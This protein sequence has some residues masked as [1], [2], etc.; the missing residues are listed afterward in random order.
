M[1]RDDDAAAAVAGSARPRRRTRAPSRAASAVDRAAPRSRAPARASASARA[2]VDARSDRGACDLVGGRA[3]HRRSIT[4]GAPRRASPVRVHDAAVHARRCRAPPN[5]DA[6]RT[7]LPL[8]PRPARAR[9]S[10]SSSSAGSCACRRSS[11]TSL[12]GIV[13]G[14]HALALG[15]GIDETTRYLA[16]FGIVFLMFSIGLEF[17]LPQLRAMRRAVFGLGL[18]Q[19]AITTVAGDGRRCTVVGFG[20]QAGLVLGGA[21]AMSST[22]IVS[23]MLAERMRAR[24]AAR[25]RHHGHPAVPGPRGRR[26]PDRHPV[27]RRSRG[28]DL[29][30]GAG[31]RGGQGGGRAG[32]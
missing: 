15:A 5:A 11:A 10:S 25:A 21:L 20:W 3:V 27:A 13:V 7:T 12:V 19:V 18:A 2:R 17:S 8:D 26:V 23:K 16:E 9:P 1:P 14:P 4:A 30:A 22:A 24:H 6:C 29:A 31:A 28:S 32:A